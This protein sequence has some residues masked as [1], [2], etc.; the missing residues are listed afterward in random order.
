[1]QCPNCQQPAKQLG[2]DRVKCATCG[3]FQRNEKG[4]W[5]LDGPAPGPVD[6][7]GRDSLPAG[8]TNQ[9]PAAESP[10]D[11]PLEVWDGVWIRLWDGEE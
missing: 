4:E 10:V 3:E 5:T 6:S 8:E 2:P 1:M 7:S 9:K 11:P